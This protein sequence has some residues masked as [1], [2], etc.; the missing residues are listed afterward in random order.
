MIALSA[1][2]MAGDRAQALEAG[3]DDYDTKPVDLAGLIFRI[4]ALLG[5]DRE[6]PARILVVDD[7]GA[8][9]TR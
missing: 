4:E 5:A 3:C 9:A 2:A 6:R 8:T 1:H 7:N